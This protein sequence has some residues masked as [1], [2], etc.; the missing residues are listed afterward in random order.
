M[1]YAD[2]LDAY[3][4]PIS[5]RSI[6][7]T[8]AEQARNLRKGIGDDLFGLLEWLGLKRAVNADNR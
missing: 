5:S 2:E 7:E 1:D 3:I 8:Q 4:K 6:E